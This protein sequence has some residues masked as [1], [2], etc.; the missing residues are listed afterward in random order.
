MSRTRRVGPSPEVL[1]LLGRAIRC[2]SLTVRLPDGHDYRFGGGGGLSSVVTIS[3]PDLFKRVLRDGDIGFG[4]AYA[5]R[6]WDVADDDLVSLLGI[7]FVNDLRAAFRGS[8]RAQMVVAAA[9]LRRNSARPSKENVHRHY[10]LSNEFFGLFLDGSMT[11]SCGYADALDVSLSQMQLNKYEIIC[12]KLDLQP[13]DRLLDI[14][15]G[16]GGLMIY[17]TLTRGVTAVGVTLSGEQAAWARSWIA[18]CGLIGRVDVRVL[19]YRAVNEVFDK[20]VSVGMFEHVGVEYHRTFVRH[21]LDRLRPGGRALLHT[22]GTTGSRH[23]S[24]WLRKHIFPGVALP[25]LH[26]IARLVTECGGSVGHVDNWKVHY[27]ETAQRWRQRFVANRSEIARLGFDE[28]FLRGWDFYLQLLEA[29]FRYDCLQLYQVLFAGTR[30]WA[31]PLD[32][33]FADFRSGRPAWPA[34]MLVGGEGDVA[35]DGH[36]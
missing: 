33:G 6:W 35:S 26:D 15:C 19:D 27:A 14:G 29:C 18:R 22:I 8:W 21:A 3:D 24:P 36:R 31:V 1:S 7:L 16:W 17:A 23:P 20:V 5:E 28:Q 30:S 4:E 2:G 13:G 12:R 10:D 11:Y 32:L 25:Q 34:E 9:M